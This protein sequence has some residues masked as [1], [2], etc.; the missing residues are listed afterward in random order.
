[1]RTSVVRTSSELSAPPYTSSLAP[2][3][4]RR[5]RFGLLVTLRR[6]FGQTQCAENEFLRRGMR[7]IDCGACW[8]YSYQ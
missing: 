1:M 7:R 8:K 6:R 4:F 5:P 3:L 2:S